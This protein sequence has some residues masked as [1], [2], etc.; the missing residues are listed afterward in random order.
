[1]LTNDELIRYAR[2]IQI[3][4]FGEAGQEK[5]KQAKIIIAGIGGLGSSAAMYLTAAGV[6]TIRIID[7]DKVELS[8]LNRQVLYCDNDIGKNKVATASEKLSRLNPEVNIEAVK[9]KITESNVSQLVSGFDLIVDAMDNLPA[10]YLLNRAA[11][12]K[13][14]PFFHGAVQGF[15]GMATTIIPGETACLRCV[16]RGAIPQQKNL[17]FSATIFLTV[18]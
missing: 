8:N 13:N 4:G 17:F 15:E 18:P 1:M 11:L 6:G 9:E 7:H 14:M 3:Y 5:L 10:R 12:D 2:Q 16:Y